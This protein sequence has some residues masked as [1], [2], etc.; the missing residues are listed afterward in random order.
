VLTEPEGTTVTRYI[1]GRF[2]EDLL[3]ISNQTFSNETKSQFFQ[4]SNLT[5][6]QNDI[7]M[8]YEIQGDGWLG[9]ADGVFG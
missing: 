8:V 5:N 6:A 4:I 2:A 7:S 3:T 1:Q 9:L